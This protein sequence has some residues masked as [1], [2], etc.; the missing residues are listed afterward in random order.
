VPS[1]F[2][3]EPVMHAPTRLP[4]ALAL[5]SCV[6]AI[7][8]TAQ[9]PTLPGYQGRLLRADGTAATG[10]ASVAFR[11]F[12]A[13]TGGSALWT[14]T[15]TLGLSDG[16]YSTFLG[17]VAPPPATLFDGG[18]RWLEVAVGAQTLVPRLRIGSAPYAVTAQNVVGS[19]DVAS[20]KVGGQIV[21]DADGRLA[22]PAR[23]AAG[24]GIAVDS[25]TVSLL[26][27][28]A[29]QVLVH[30]ATS[31][32]CAAANAGS[33][34]S[35][36]A[37][38]PMSVS[39]ASTTPQLSIA[40]AG[41]G[42]AGYL[43]T[44]DWA[45]FNAKYDG[46]TQCGGDLAGVLSAPTVVRLQS[47]AVSAAAPQNGQVL[48]WNASGL[49]WEPA[50]DS[51]SGGTVR[52]VTVAAPLTSYNG[53]MT[54]EISLAQ[55]GSAGDGYLSSGDWTRFNA[56][57]DSNTQCTGDLSG[58][59]LAPQ[60][61][62]LQGVSVATTVPGAAQVLRFDG[63][64]W[65][66][67]S[68]QIGDVG[69]L[70]GGYLD[71]SGTQT[72]GGAKTFTAAPSFG[73]PLDV[74]SGGIGTTSAE[75][76]RVFAG[77]LSGAG[78]PSFRLLDPTD[79]PAVDA[80][81]ITGGTL[82]V[83]RGGT[84]TTS[85]SGVVHGN[86]T[87]AFTASNVDLT[88]EVTGTLP[89]ANGGTGST[90]G[91]VTAPG[92][93][94]FAA[95]AGQNVA[96]TPGGGGYTLLGGPVGIDTATP[97][98]AL[99]VNGAVNIPV[100][101]PY[102]SAGSAIV[103]TG[104]STY[105]YVRAYGSGG[106]QFQDPAGSAAMSMSSAGS[107]GVGTTNP[108]QILHLESTGTPALAFYTSFAGDSSARNWAIR[109]N[110]SVWGN[111]EFLQSNA[112]GGNPV[113]A[114]TS[115]LAISPSGNVGVGTST[116]GSLLHVEDRSTGASELRVFKNTGSGG[117]HAS[118]KV[119]YDDGSRLEIW[120]ARDDA[121]IHFDS[122]Q[123]GGRMLFSTNTASFGFTGG[124]VGIGTTGPSGELEL[125]R[126]SASYG[127]YLKLTNTNGGGYTPRLQFGTYGYSGSPAG[128]FTLLSVE[129]DYSGAAGSRV[130]FSMKDQPQSTAVEALTIQATGNVAVAGSIQVGADNAACSGTNQGALRFN[131]G[132]KTLEF[133]DG[134][135]WRSLATTTDNTTGFVATRGTLTSDGRGWTAPAGGY[136]SV[137]LAK[138]FGPGQDFELVTYWAHTFRGVG[139]VYGPTVHHWDWNGYSPSDSAGPYWGALGTAG[140][141]SGYSGTYFGQYHA[142]IQGDGG[143]T[144]GYWFRHR[145]LGNTLSLEYSSTSAT[146]PWTAVKAAATCA[147][148][149]QVVVG[150]GQASGTV[151][152]QLTI[153]SLTYGGMSGV[154]YA[155]TPWTVD[156]TTGFRGSVGTFSNGN[157]TWSA[158][159]TSSYY[160]V[161]LDKTFDAGQAFE[162]VTY[163]Q[164]NYRGTGMVYGPSVA[165][166]GFGGGNNAYW[167]A[168]GTSGF[169][170]GTFMGQY[171]APISGDGGNMTAYWFRHS[172][173]G[174]TLYLEYSSESSQ[175]RWSSIVAP[176]TISA[177]DKVVVG[178]GEAGSSET[179]PL[180][181]VRLRY[182]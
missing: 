135:V 80:S 36:S 92:A 42:S 122:S 131:T 70:S 178:L 83:A 141:P 76:N 180:Q 143:N 28:T 144:T 133:C 60:V 94:T 128:Q 146:G 30:D 151:E 168:L 79:I 109:P 37:A 160:G 88:G 93:L 127:P 113:T 136:T 1:H 75:A 21:V 14:E 104:G 176:V 13:A 4:L 9:V 153:V 44:A 172:R 35:I 33:V 55:A 27:C 41:S 166:T 6:F 112:A 99:D 63:S 71:L 69:G 139:M 175:G 59:Y 118:L 64:A 23:I 26:P 22:G 50:P 174:N 15:Q 161:A 62:K 51:D 158:G 96:L 126:S 115:R 155:P 145:R 111:I 48:K 24:P 149:D 156:A 11:V 58:T 121:D 38:A 65:V 57:Y 68:L 56:K 150:L 101:T 140:F 20:L 105:T 117:P 164:E 130:R 173:V 95:G 32:Q 25:Q 89:V 138:T 16:Y 34:T 170:S 72:I 134:S 182:R 132:S 159:N 90:T 179:T 18:A 5:F 163:W 171:H 110:H 10:T 165:A 78:A 73:T 17:L 120:R 152:G 86:G 162:L 125:A 82:S 124:N 148:S 40:Q 31:W 167:S 49:Q 97:G 116:P 2:D 177:S 137:A 157:R 43:S 47:H 114:G 53:S 39:D 106:I 66:P 91:S 100:N 81:Q 67:A 147:A 3:E 8:A 123:A 87:G 129:T 29:G 54:P 84:G 142:P 119:G 108:S 85:L 77:P 102:R 45:R 98:H 46:L 74:A 154:L 7:T 12:D 181:I 169:S 19:A 52:S 107:L 103:G 61:S